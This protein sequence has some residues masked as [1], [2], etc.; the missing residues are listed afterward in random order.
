MTISPS[1]YPKI[2]FVK[3]AWS[4]EYQGQ[5]VFGRHE[6]LRINKDGHERFNFKP[7]PDG[8]YYG[9]IPPHKTPEDAAGWLVI[10]VA[11]ST[12]DN[13]KTFG[14]LLPVGWY[15]DAT[16]VD[17]QERPEYECIKDFTISRGGTKY[18]YRVESNR[19]FLIPKEMRSIRLPV[20]HGRKMGQASK[21]VVKSPN[22]ASNLDQWRIDYAQYA[23]DLLN[24][25]SP[26]NGQNQ[27]NQDKMAIEGSTLA[28]DPTNRGYAT[29]EHKRRVEKSAEKFAKK[30]FKKEFIIKD[31][32]KENLGYD[33]H[34]T[35][36][37]SGRQ[38][39]LEVKG[40][41]SVREMFYLTRNELKCLKKNEANF[42][43]LLVTR[44]L[45]TEPEGKLF[46]ASLV[47]SQFSLEPLA[48]QVTSRKEH[49]KTS[50]L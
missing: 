48:Y 34:L 3:T 4:D 32:T 43:L 1:D 17:E 8:R 14:P 45:S 24:K 38:I 16:F 39:L 35:E 25:L 6:Y 23:I 49:L 41:S 31:V 47:V 44:A 27:V 5:E 21:V 2:C 26:G 19:A 40:T 13:G 29:T 18:T 10:F 36:R 33:F 28:E 37:K 42:H 12:N 15:E 30:L 22:S 50:R 20:E 11:A 46:S 9:Y 7:G